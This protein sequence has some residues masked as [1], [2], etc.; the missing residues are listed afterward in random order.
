[1]R[2]GYSRRRQ[3]ISDEA[4][5]GERDCDDSCY[6]GDTLNGLGSGRNTFIPSPRFMIAVL[7]LF[8][9][10][11]LGALNSL[12]GSFFSSSLFDGGGS[13]RYSGGYASPKALHRTAGV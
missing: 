8:E 2:L 1:P 13:L 12:R 6:D 5:D 11:S 10:S 3:Q 7:A 4:C 9:G